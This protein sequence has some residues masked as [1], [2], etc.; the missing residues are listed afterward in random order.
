MD[1]LVLGT[2]Q[3]GLEYGHTNITGMPTAIQAL[4]IIN[5][6]LEKG[7]KTFDTA[8]SYGTA[9]NVLGQ[10]NSNDTI[11]IIT[12]LGKFNYNASE[13]ILKN[14]IDKSIEESC[15]ALQVSNLD[16]LLIHDFE[17][18]N[19]KIIWKHL[20]SLQEKNKI[21]KLGI[22]VYNVEE[23]I[24]ALKD[25]NINH[26]QLPIN[27]I[28]SQWNNDIFLELV[29]QRSDVSIHARSIFLQGILLNDT[30]FWPKNH[31]SAFYVNTLDNLMVDFGFSNKVELCFSYVKS[32]KWID[33]IIM[34]V[35]TLLQLKKNI[36]LFNVR[37]MDEEKI[38]KIRSI[39]NA[40]PKSIVDPRL[41]MQTIN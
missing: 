25:I 27:I 7:I 9:E 34:G 18:F 23:A 31:D 19:N 22:S 33:G 10:I 15:K 13:S 3:L 28:D 24:I 14:N 32:L 40:T 8:R 36:E 39:F 29:K 12:K 38:Q 6:A 37:T 41:W 20:L 35:D 26:I 21:G 16:T 30:S 5:Y 17:H 4:S 1:R 11:T 2:A